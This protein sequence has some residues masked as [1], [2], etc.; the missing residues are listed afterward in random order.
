MGYIFDTALNGQGSFAGKAYF[1]RDDLYVRYDWAA[2]A[3]DPDYP[4]S[5][6]LWNL[7]APFHTGVDAALNGRGIFRDKAY[8]FRGDQYVRYDWTTEEVEGPSSLTAW[9]LPAD[10]VTGIDAVLEGRGPFLGKAYFFKANQYL[11]YDWTTQ[12]VDPGYPASLD[13]WALPGSF[14]RDVHATLNGE[15]PYQGYAYFF[16][17]PFYIRYTWA[18]E[19]VGG[20]THIFAWN[21]RGR[22]G[23]G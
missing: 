3:T 4:A 12:R 15:G 21:L 16:R 13:A 18:T 6:A 19:E 17:G 5:L 9:D 20:R 11:R 10:F 1:F 22:V 14:R 8:F 2:N 7:P 23:S